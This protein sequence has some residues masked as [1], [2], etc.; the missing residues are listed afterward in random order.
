MGTLDFELS[1]DAVFNWDPSLQH[2]R[3]SPKACGRIL[4]LFQRCVDRS[5]TRKTTRKRGAECRTGAVNDELPI[6]FADAALS[7]CLQQQSEE[8]ARER[9]LVDFVSTRSGLAG[10]VIKS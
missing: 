10:R 3:R 5:W 2:Y 4:R 7:H 6:Y 9:Y 1:W 8:C